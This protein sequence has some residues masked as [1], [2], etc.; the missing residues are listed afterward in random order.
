MV[1][2]FESDVI[3]FMW[4]F[5][6]HVVILCLSSMKYAV[7]G[8]SYVACLGRSDLLLCLPREVAFWAWRNEGWICT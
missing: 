5:D 2:S 4:V 6:L 3:S 8:D 1:L 7:F